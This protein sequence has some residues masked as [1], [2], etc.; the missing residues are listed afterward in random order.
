METLKPP[1]RKCDYEFEDKNHE[2]CA[3]CPLPQAYNEALNKKQFQTYKF[4]TTATKNNWGVKKPKPKT[5]PIDRNEIGLKAWKQKTYGLKKKEKR[6][7]E[8]N[9]INT[10]SDERLIEGYIEQIC[11]DYG[12][13]VEKLKAK[14]PGRPTTKVIEIRSE[15]INVLRSGKF[16][17]LTN[18]EI[19]DILK[20]RERSI[21]SR[22]SKKQNG[23]PG[24][25]P[26]P[27]SRKILSDNTPKDPPKPLKLEINFNKHSTVYEDLEQLA[28]ENLR[29]LENQVLWMFVRIHAI[30]MKEFNE[31]L[32]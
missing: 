14:T 1:C 13:T 19:G 26:D 31:K 29:T 10:T 7:M 12:I 4:L 17:K 16:G 21:R 5:K 32:S 24:P 25:G 30:G 27:S 28:E 9:H 6:K 18:T 8:K 11:K 2:P 15:I 23:K 3:S 20:V 22:L